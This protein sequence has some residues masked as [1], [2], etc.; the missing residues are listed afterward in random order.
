MPGAPQPPVSPWVYT[1]AD[2]QGN[3]ITAT[4]TFNNST[5]ALQSCTIVRQS[6]CVYSH[7]YFGLGSDGIPNDT[8]SQFGPV[9]VGTTNANAQQMASFGFTT[10][11][12]VLAG[13]VTAGP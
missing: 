13:Q 7:I 10:I 5:L 2:Y 6:G 8:P 3:T 12:Q 1:A 11:T 9:A 4:V